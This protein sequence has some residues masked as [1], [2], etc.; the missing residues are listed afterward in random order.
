MIR[1][2]VAA[3]AH[4]TVMESGPGSLTDFYSENNGYTLAKR[5]DLP[6]QSIPGIRNGSR[7]IALD[8][9]FKIAI[10]LELDPAQVVADLEEQREKN[11]QRREFWRSFLLRAAMLLAV[12]ARTLALSSSATFDSA[13][14]ALLGRSSRRDWFA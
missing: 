11:E 14:R 4:V 2:R 12:L 8:I 5:L 13:T 7:A 3:I 1:R 6:K 9:A 10:A